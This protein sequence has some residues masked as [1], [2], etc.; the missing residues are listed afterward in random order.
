M[1]AQKL[2]HHD[3]PNKRWPKLTEAMDLQPYSDLPGTRHDQNALYPMF[4]LNV[5]WDVDDD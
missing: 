5:K 1:T 4:K 3:L 2:A